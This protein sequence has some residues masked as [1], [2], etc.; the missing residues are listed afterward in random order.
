[1]PITVSIFFKSEQQNLKYTTYT[2][3]N[4]VARISELGEILVVFDSVRFFV[5]NFFYKDCGLWTSFCASELSTFPVKKSC[6]PVYRSL[7]MSSMVT[8]FIWL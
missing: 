5:E 1:M 8:D 7:Q 3:K 6:V 4:Q 2:K